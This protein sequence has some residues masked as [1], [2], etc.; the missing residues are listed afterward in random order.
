METTPVLTTKMLRLTRQK[1]VLSPSRLDKTIMNK[2]L[3]TYRLL[4]SYI[5]L[6]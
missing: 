3:N 2:I 5:F 6:I 1:C 4:D